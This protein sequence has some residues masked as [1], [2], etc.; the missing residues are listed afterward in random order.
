MTP[1]EKMIWAAAFAAELPE[2]YAQA[3]K[4]LPLTERGTDKGRTKVAFTAHRAAVT[5]AYFAVESARAA[6]E[7]PGIIPEAL[8]MLADAL[9]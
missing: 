3:R 6:A 7:T 8:A 2:A 9:S 4:E 1:G 5:K